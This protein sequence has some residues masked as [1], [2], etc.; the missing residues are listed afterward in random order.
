M[1]D[2]TFENVSRKI[3]NN[4]C[5]KIFMMD[6]I[7]SFNTNIAYQG[8]QISGVMVLHADNLESIQMM[9][10]MLNIVYQELKNEHLKKQQEDFQDDHAAAIDDAEDDEYKLV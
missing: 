2:V 10:E 9:P 5:N 3:F 7:T 8:N 4:C 1:T 6:G